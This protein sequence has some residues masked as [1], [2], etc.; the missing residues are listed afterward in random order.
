MRSAAAGWITSAKSFTSPIGAGICK[1]W[2]RKSEAAR[3]TTISVAV[4]GKPIRTV[5]KIY[6][7]LLSWFGRRSI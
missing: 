1:P 6:S 5:V 3:R 7:P 4:E 2:K